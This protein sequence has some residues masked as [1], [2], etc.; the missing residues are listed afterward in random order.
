MLAVLLYFQAA[1]FL[2]RKHFRDTRYIAQMINE[3]ESIKL[4]RHCVIRDQRGAGLTKSRRTT[5]SQAITK[6]TFM[7]YL[8]VLANRRI[9]D[10]IL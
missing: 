7:R 9:F 5:T 6:I 2:F 3:A 1:E 4:H 8:N 10:G